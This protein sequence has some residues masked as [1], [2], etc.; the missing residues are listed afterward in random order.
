MLFKE[1]SNFKVADNSGAIKIKC[2]GL[3]KG[4]KKKIAKLND[5]ILCVVKKYNPKKKLK[6]KII[7]FGLVISIVFNTKRKDGSIIR[8]AFNRVLLFSKDYKFLGTRVYGPICKEFKMGI[9]SLKFKDQ[10]RKI[11]SYS[12]YT[13]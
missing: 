8:F 4:P 5:W 6:K 10:I 13:L 1:S 11:V 9:R 12:Q 3:F 2:I 7:Y